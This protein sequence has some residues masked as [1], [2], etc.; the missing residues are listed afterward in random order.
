MGRPDERECVVSRHR[1]VA[2][3]E[4]PS[5]TNPTLSIYS[6][7]DWLPSC[8]AAGPSCAFE[9]LDRSAAETS[10]TQEFVRFVTASGR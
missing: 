6:I 3:V 7:E 5:P 2:R 8:P 10:E 1:W 4:S 9:H